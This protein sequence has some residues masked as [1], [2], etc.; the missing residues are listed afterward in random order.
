MHACMHTDHI[1]T[2]CHCWSVC[3]ECHTSLLRMFEP[4]ARL[5]T[6]KPCSPPCRQNPGRPPTGVLQKKVGG[7]FVERHSR[8]VKSMHSEPHSCLTVSSKPLVPASTL[9]CAAQP[10]TPANHNSSAA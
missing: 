1:P 10:P 3:G 9:T 6:T 5:L 4:A 2:P 8:G 7:L